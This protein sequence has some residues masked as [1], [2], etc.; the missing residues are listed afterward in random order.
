MIECA[1]LNVYTCI[2]PMKSRIVRS[3]FFISQSNQSMKHL[4]NKLMLNYICTSKN[5]VHMRS[6][7]TPAGSGKTGFIVHDMIFHQQQHKT[8]QIFQVCFCWLHSDNPY[9]Q[10]EALMELWPAWGWLYVAVQ[11]CS[12]E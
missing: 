8:T 5:Q 11:L 7:L 4:R 2:P 6:V 1:L 3:S 9:E 12:V 10:S